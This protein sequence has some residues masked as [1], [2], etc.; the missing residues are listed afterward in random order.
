VPSWVP[1]SAQRDFASIV[2]APDLFFDFD[3]D[4]SAIATPTSGAQSSF[5]LNA[6]HS[7]DVPS[8]QLD[9]SKFTAATTKACGHCALTWCTRCIEGSRQNPPV[10]CHVPEHGRSVCSACASGHNVVSVPTS[11]ALFVPHSLETAFENSFRHAFAPGSTVATSMQHIEIPAPFSFFYTHLNGTARCFEI[12]D[13]VDEALWK[14]PLAFSRMYVFGTVEAAN[15]MR[16]LF[17]QFM[18]PL[19]SDPDCASADSLSFRL[20]FVLFDFLDFISDQL[21]LIFEHCQCPMLHLSS[22]ISV[23]AFGV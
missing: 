7:V 22:T 1:T 5:D 12:F 10:S 3:F 23:C 8:M 4:V 21:Y 15:C 2:Q 14:R 19:R 20:W 17:A 18:F 11:H 9:F 6:N 13:A 16:S